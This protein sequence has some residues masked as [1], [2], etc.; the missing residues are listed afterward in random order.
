MT[1]P[2]ISPVFIR[3]LLCLYGNYFC[4]YT[5]KAVTIFF[6]PNIKWKASSNSETF[7]HWLVTI[8]R[9]NGKKL[10]S[11]IF[12]EVTSSTQKDE[13]A[14]PNFLC[15]KF[16]WWNN[17]KYPQQI[18]R[19]GIVRAS[20]F[21]AHDIYP[22]RPTLRK[23]KSSDHKRKHTERHIHVQVQTPENPKYQQ[24]ILKTFGR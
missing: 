1:N 16:F 15:Y 21:F 2:H 17:I 10:R 22:T 7:S 19:W 18:V 12:F 20:F 23:V 8:A 9:I 14:S 24:K 11:S 5:E 3:K 13:G 4:V 6:Y